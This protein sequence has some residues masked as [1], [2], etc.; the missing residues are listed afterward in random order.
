MADQLKQALINAGL[1]SK[2][3]LREIER[4]KVHKKHL[5]GG[6]KMRDDH[7]RIVCEACGKSAPD[8]ERYGHRNRMIEGKE[9]LCI[10]CADQY[11]ILDDCRQ[12][13]QSSHAKTKLF[14]RQY[15]PTKK[16]D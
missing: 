11:Q 16:F 15:G 6:R 13:N 12:T 10:K 4:E 2:D 7:L 3:K 5:K 8:V 1:V 14:I 9:W